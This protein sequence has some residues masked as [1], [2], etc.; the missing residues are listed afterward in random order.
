MRDVQTVIQAKINAQAGPDAQVEAVQ[1][2]INS[3]QGSSGAE[4]TYFD[5]T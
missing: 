2:H 4:I 5:V 1:Q 3:P